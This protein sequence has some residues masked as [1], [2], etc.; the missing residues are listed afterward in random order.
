MSSL[1]FLIPAEATEADHARAFLW[2]W[3]AI[4]L[5]AFTIAATK[6]PNYILPIYPAVGAA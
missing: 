3:I 4:Y 2:G 5:I 6:L 1:R